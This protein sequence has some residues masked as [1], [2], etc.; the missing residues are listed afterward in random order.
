MLKTKKLLSIIIFIIMMFLYCLLVM[1]F[2]IKINFNN[3]LIE[4]IVYFILGIL[5]IFPA[6]YIL[7]PFKKNEKK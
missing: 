1:A 5:W 7:N 6:M 4:L 2:L 3:W